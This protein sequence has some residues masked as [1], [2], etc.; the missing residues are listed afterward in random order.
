MAHVIDT[1]PRRMRPP[2]PGGASGRQTGVKPPA[3]PWPTCRPGDEDT[4]AQ[5][6][7]PVTAKNYITGHTAFISE[8]R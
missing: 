1:R 4:G 7:L 3:W 5:L 2:L 6:P 8:L